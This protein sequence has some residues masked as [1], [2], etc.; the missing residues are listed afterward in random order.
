MAAIHIGCCG[1]YCK[2]CRAF[3]DGHCRGCRL[4]YDT[5]QRDLSRAKCRMKLCCMVERHLD[6]CAE[7]DDFSSCTILQEWYG[8][9]S[10][11]YRRY[12]ESAEYVREHGSDRFV[13]IADGWKDACGRLS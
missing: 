8:K 9:A 12:K 2:T 3:R 4:G 11:K 7:C 1:A 10:G 6:T 13:E 5:G